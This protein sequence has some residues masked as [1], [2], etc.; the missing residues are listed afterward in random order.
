MKQ[1]VE[2]GIGNSNIVTIFNQ[3]KDTLDDFINSSDLKFLSKTELID[4]RFY[5]T[6]IF[7]DSLADLSEGDCLNKNLPDRLLWLMLN[8]EDL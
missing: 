2:K 1:A 6:F 7:N 5:N 8:T 4:K 3:Y